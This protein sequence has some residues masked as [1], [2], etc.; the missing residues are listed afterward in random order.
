[1]WREKLHAVEALARAFDARRSSK[2]HDEEEDGDAVELVTSVPVDGVTQAL[3]A[4][5]DDDEPLVAY[6]ALRHLEQHVVATMQQH[7]AESVTQC[8]LLVE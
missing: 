4:Y 6:A 2:C 3:V 7:E 8:E 1:M 5:L